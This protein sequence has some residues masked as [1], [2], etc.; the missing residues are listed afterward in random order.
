MTA[1]CFS[2]GIVLVAMFLTAAAFGAG[3]GKSLLGAPGAELAGWSAPNGAFTAT[4]ERDAAVDGCVCVRLATTATKKNEW[5]WVISPA[6]AAENGYVLLTVWMKTSNV[7]QSHVKV[8]GFDASG[9]RVLRNG[10]DVLVSCPSGRNG[11]SA[12]TRYQARFDPKRFAGCASIKVCLMAGWSPD[13]TEA[14]TWFGGITLA[15]IP[16]E[17]ARRTPPSCP[18]IEDAVVYQVNT[19]TTPLRELEERLPALQDLGITC[20]YLMP[21][22]ETGRV[23]SIGSSYCIRDYYSIR[24]SVGSADDLKRLVGAAH[25]RGIRIIMDLVINHTAWDNVLTS[26]HPEWY[27][28]DASGGFLIP[29]GTGWK[30]AVQLDYSKGGLRRYMIDMM[31][32]WVREFG[33]DG[34]RCDAAA[35]IPADFWRD[36]RRELEAERP[37]ILFFAEIFYSPD[38]ASWLEAFH[39]GYFGIFD[40]KTV[41]ER[42]HNDI[43][44]LWFEERMNFP[45]HLLWMRMTENHDITREKGPA[46]ACYGKE[47]A[48]LGAVLIATL[49]G[50]P[51]IYQGQEYCTGAETNVKMWQLVKQTPTAAMEAERAFYRKLFGIRKAH[52]AL[53]SGDVVAVRANDPDVGCFLRVTDGDAV[54][55]MLNF[56][57]HDAA[58]SIELPLARVAAPGGPIT[59]RDELTGARIVPDGTIANFK[60]KVPARRALVLALDPKCTALMKKTGASTN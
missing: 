30:D 16:A 32:H 29:P 2:V 22:H 34:F 41:F 17:N 9:G 37:D 38:C 26:E 20:C 47:L 36:A 43:Y 18:W 10:S 4:V 50:V 60:V 59:F 39:A 21:I 56:S 57:N 33:I 24:A 48:D 25:A 46:A 23:K 28:H 12:W 54:L 42:K 55:P 14:V 8:L 7:Q 13:G 40:R 51:M 52:P 35:M 44:G 27:S 19:D 45:P 15:R 5:S 31:R 6:I 53:R 58:V 11:N 1:H 49:D 3:G